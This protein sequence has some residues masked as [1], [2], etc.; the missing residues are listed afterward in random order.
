MVIVIKDASMRFMSVQDWAYVIIS[1]LMIV[2]FSW[3]VGTYFDT[4]D[5]LALENKAMATK[6][7]LTN[8]GMVISY[9][10]GGEFFSRFVRNTRGKRIQAEL[11]MERAFRKLNGEDHF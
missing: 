3:C 6:I 5:E 8:I 4:L 11:D 1:M 7:V 2:L 9:I 10:V